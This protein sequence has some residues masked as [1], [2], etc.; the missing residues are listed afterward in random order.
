MVLVR[1]CLTLKPKHISILTLCRLLSVPR[2]L[3]ARHDARLLDAR[4][5]ILKRTM[6]PN[7]HFAPLTL[8][9][10]A[11]CRNPPSSHILAWLGSARSINEIPLQ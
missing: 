11:H 1:S 4:T 10:S 9:R 3:G 5:H 6:A 7:D 2:S 8:I